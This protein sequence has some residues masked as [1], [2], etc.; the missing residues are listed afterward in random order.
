MRFLRD[1]LSLVLLTGILALGFLY[2]TVIVWPAYAR[3]DSLMKLIQKREDNIKEMTEHKARW[4]A[5]LKERLQVQ[6]A[7]KKRDK[8]FTL[9]SFLEGISREAGIE[10][11]I[12]YMKPL[13]VQEGGSLIKQ[14]GIEVGLEDIG[15]EQ[16]VDLLQRTEYS[17][18]L[19]KVKRIKIQRSEKEKGKV[20]LL[21]VTLQ[22]NTFASS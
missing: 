21:K 12:K 17:G 19:I 22:V 1:H 14:E 9:L 20:V 4:E 7:M 2:S 15:I 13:T 5:F 11:R 3:K 18:K 8:G 16:L 6:D 10:Q